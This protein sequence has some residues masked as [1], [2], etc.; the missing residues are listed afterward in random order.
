MEKLKRILFCGLSFKH[1]NSKA[2]IL[3]KQYAPIV[4]ASVGVPFFG[5]EK[6]IYLWYTIQTIHINIQHQLKVH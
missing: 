6:M 4:G 1:Y 2:L 3:E 5:L